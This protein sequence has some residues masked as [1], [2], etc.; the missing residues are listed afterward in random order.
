[1]I[2]FSIKTEDGKTLRISSP[3]SWSEINLGQLI[4]IETKWDKKS[5][6]Q[7]F[8][9]ITGLD[10]SLLSNSKEKGL[11]DKL[12]AICA[13]VYD[14]PD[15]EHMPVP[16]RLWIGDEGYTT[17]KDISKKM[18]GQKI[19]INGIAIKEGTDLIKY[20]PRIVAIYMQ[21][22]ID[23]DFENDRLEYI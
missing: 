23:G 12:M 2:Q 6:I 21:P 20:I 17:P 18:L 9:I 10:I 3:A 5:P 7:L 1:M 14:Q 19:M 4:A 11:E 16:K 22:I 15:W 8:S 13:F